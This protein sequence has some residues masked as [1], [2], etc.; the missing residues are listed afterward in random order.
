MS[1]PGTTYRSRDEIQKMRSQQDPIRGLQRYLAEWEVTTEENLKASH[2]LTSIIDRLYIMLQAIDKQAKEEVDQ[3]V[4][5]AKESPEPLVKDLWT[6][7]YYKGT[8]P[9]FMR[10]R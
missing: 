2:F 4:A 5:E 6:D 1:D 10:G 8:E 7:I 9:P 3:A